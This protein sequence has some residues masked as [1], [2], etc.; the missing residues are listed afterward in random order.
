MDKKEVV[1]ILK[2]ISDMK[3]FEILQIV[4]CEETCICD[5]Q[6]KFDVTQPTLSYDMK[7]LQDLGL[8]NSRKDGKWNYYSLNK[9]KLEEFY[10][11]LG[12]L[13]T[14]NKHCDLSFKT[15]K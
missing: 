3:R 13:L 4:N 2:A 8:V 9:E 7:K 6:D 14:E 12:E 1:D 5:F 10:V 15:K 11:T